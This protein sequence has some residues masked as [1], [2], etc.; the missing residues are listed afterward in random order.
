MVCGVGDIDEIEGV[1]RSFWVGMG[2]TALEDTASLQPISY[3]RWWEGE[4]TAGSG[5][6]TFLRVLS[7]YFF[8]WSF[9][10]EYSE[11]SQERWCLSFNLTESTIFSAVD[12]TNKL[13]ME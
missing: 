8:S 4:R 2:V 6:S 10:S 1:R 9:S 11:D 13:F 7:L 3:F 12:D 5:L